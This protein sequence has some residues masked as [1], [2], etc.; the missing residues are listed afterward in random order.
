MS[1][2]IG[3]RERTSRLSSWRRPP[4]M[5]VCP[6]RTR[7]VV[8]AERVVFSGR[9]VKQGDKIPGTEYVVETVT[10]TVVII[11][12]E[13][14]DR[15]EVYTYEIRSV[16]E[17]VSVLSHRRTRTGPARTGSETKE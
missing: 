3:M 16:D 1:D 6:S 5:S 12:G 11:R 17:S 7:T 15:I 10:A 2:R 9:P 8:S 13:F 14:P 4:T